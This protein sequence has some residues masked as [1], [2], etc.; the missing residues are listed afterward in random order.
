MGPA[1]RKL[2]AR[3]AHAGV[4]QQTWRAGRLLRPLTDVLRAR[5]DLPDDKSQVEGREEAEEYAV[6]G[7]KPPDGG[8]QVP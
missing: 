8:A 3:L 7:D 6:P 2:L 4:K 1:W 5:Q